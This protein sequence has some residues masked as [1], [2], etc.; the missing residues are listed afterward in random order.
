MSTDNIFI[1]VDA[2]A[3]RSFSESPPE[4]R[5]KIELLLAQRLRELT[6]GRVRS[7]NEIMDE[8]GTEAEAKGLTPETLEAMLG[9]E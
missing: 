1:T 3:A 5:R 9:E 6:T 8:I 4:E 7:L 2:D